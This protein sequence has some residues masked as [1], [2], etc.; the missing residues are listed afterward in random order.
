MKKASLLVLAMTIVIVSQAQIRFGAR[1]GLNISNVV[2][3]ETSGWKSKAGIFIGG[4][5]E[6]PVLSKFS[7]QPELYYSM[8]GAKWDGEDGAKTSLGY[9]KLPVLARYTLPAGFYG[10][11]GPQIG[12]LLNATDTYD[13]EKE[14]IK[15][16]LK[17]TEFSWVVGA[18]Y[19]VTPQIGVHARYNASFSS[20]YET[21]KNSVFQIGVQYIL[22]QAGK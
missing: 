21:E 8:E 1:G 16:Y 11:T 4:F 22:G 10:E 7:V 12:F 6:I 3:K 17:K 5:A 14:D 15:E 13:G 18:G 9:I 2:G 20:F 19:F